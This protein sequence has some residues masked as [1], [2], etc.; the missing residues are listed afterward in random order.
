VKPNS[1]FFPDRSPASWGADGGE[2]LE[3]LDAL[4]NADLLLIFARRMNLPDD[5]M[6][7]IR[8][9]WEA[10]RPIV[11]IRTASHAFQKPDNDIFDRQILGVFRVSVA[12]KSSEVS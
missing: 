8:A 7:P 9:H 3:N 5:Q 1:R 6:K 12:R 4:K 10:G 11:G 2:T